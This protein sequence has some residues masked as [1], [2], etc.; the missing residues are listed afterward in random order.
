M[1]HRPPVWVVVTASVAIVAVV[2]VVALRAGG[3]HQDRAGSAHVVKHAAKPVV[4]STTSITNAPLMP[5]ARAGDHPGEYEVDEIELTISDPA[6]GDRAVDIAV[7]YPHTGGPFPLVVFAHGFG[8]SPDNYA[9]FLA[10]LASAGHVVVAPRSF[11]TSV[12]SGFPGV[13]ET[14]FRVQEDDPTPAPDAGTDEPPPV[15]GNEGDGFDFNSQ[16]LDLVAAIDV[17][18]GPDP[19]EELRG[20]VANTKA[21]VIGHSDGGVTAAA[22]AFNSQVGDPRVGAGVIISGDY[23]EF[24]GEWFPDGSPALLAIHGDADGVNPI[25]SSFGLYAAD[26]G[27]PRYLVVA[28]GAG[29]LDLLT[30]DPPLSMVIGLIT[31]FLASYLGNDPAAIDRMNADADGDVLELVA[32]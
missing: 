9:D 17:V 25:A 4:P 24:G 5:V 19:P 8:T 28:H 12:S 29:H 22:V 15:S 16:R 20:R 13:Q 7:W 1:E 3:P 21:A 11:S 6:E 2:A 31:D 30:D 18:L 23:G 32:S 27:G 10:G 14:A 26:G